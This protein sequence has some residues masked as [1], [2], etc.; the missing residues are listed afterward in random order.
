MTVQLAAS[1]EGTA[2]L[3]WII[4]RAARA[5][6]ADIMCVWR[7]APL[8][9]SALAPIVRVGLAYVTYANYRTTR[10]VILVAKVDNNVGHCSR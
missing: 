2:W 4:R 10:A 5:D 3:N 1:L 6:K 7:D 8:T 9:Y